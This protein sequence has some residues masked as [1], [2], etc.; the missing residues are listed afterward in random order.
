MSGPLHSGLLLPALWALAIT[1]AL[2][3]ATALVS[4]VLTGQSHL[5]RTV[6]ALNPSLVTMLIALG[7]TPRGSVAAGS[8][9]ALVECPGSHLRLMPQNGGNGA[10]RRAADRGRQP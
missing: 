6:A 4:G 10:R 2:C 8:A 3:A 7:R 1:A 5:P 9:P